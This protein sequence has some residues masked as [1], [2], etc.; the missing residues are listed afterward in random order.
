[1][2]R[3]ALILHL[4][5]LGLNTVEVA[6]MMQITVDTLHKHMDRIYYKFNVHDRGSA[7]QKGMAC[8]AVNNS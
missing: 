5:N 7:I 2:P 6:K 3:Q 4:Y 8:S 1:M